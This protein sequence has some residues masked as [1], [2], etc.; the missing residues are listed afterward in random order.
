MGRRNGTT[1]HA[2]Y[3]P[4]RTNVVADQLSRRGQVIGTEWSLHPQVANEVFRQLG[5]PTLDLF[6]TSLNKKLA[7]YCSV[8][9]DPLAVMED[10]FMHP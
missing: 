3:L 7:L 1:L 4:G 8:L 2:R 6:A 10:A 5:T 9:P